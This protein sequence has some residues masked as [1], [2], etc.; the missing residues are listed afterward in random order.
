MNMTIGILAAVILLLGALIGFYIM[1]EDEKL[2]EQPIKAT[3]APVIPRVQVEPVKPQPIQKIAP[4]P[5]PQLKESA[6]VM[7][8]VLS[9]LVGADTFKKY[10]HPEQIVRHIVVTIDNLPNKSAAARLFPVKPVGGKFRT[11]GDEENLTISTKNPSRYT[12]YVRIAEMVDAKKL[13]AIYS[14]FSPLFQHAYQELGYPNSS[15]N[16][17]LITVIDHLLGAP[18][19]K[20]QVRLVQPN[21]MFLYADPALEAQSAGRKIMM[22]M[23]KGNEVKIKSKLREIRLEL[24]DQFSK[25]LSAK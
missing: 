1:Q 18:E 21:V 14:R 24:A 13:V 12:P 2:P 6:P 8:E 16:D 20:G 3:P 4:P 25:Q 11:S 7:R 15:F 22:R 10:F 19:I 5:L 17:R 23:G 9:D